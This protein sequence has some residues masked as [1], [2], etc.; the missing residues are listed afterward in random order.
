MFHT[1]T[2][3]IYFSFEDK[4]AYFLLLLPANFLLICCS[5]VPK[6]EKG[7]KN[8]CADYKWNNE[9]QDCE[10]CSPGYI[11][12]NCSEKCP[13]GYYGDGCQEICHC[14]VNVCN[15]SNGCPPVTTYTRTFVFPNNLESLAWCSG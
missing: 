3:Q 6:C 13:P 1:K 5:N 2:A 8:C 14:D 11:G 12:N 7:F 10:K 4:S 15:I 9:I